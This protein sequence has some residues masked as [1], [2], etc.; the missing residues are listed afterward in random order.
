MNRASRD[1]RNS[2]RPGSKDRRGGRRVRASRPQKAVL[3]TRERR[4]LWKVNAFRR[5]EWETV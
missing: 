1:R 4:R 2:S 5:P 3:L